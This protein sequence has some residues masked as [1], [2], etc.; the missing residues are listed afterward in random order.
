M[1]TCGSLGQVV[2]AVLGLAP[3]ATTF[4]LGGVGRG[5]GTYG[6]AVAEA[7]TTS[8]QAKSPRQ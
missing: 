7:D 2:G 8:K 1:S 4:V 6:Q 5:R 3:E